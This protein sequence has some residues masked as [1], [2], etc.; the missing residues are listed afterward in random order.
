LLCFAFFLYLYPLFAALRHVHVNT[1]S[2]MLCLFAVLMCGCVM[3]C[4][5]GIPH[6]LVGSHRPTLVALGV[7]VCVPLGQG[8]EGPGLSNL[9]DRQVK[10]LPKQHL[11]PTVG[12]SLLEDVSTRRG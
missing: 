1:R 12:C 8:S 4:V 6:I 5:S 9:D 3:R 2:D 7:D 10:Y 11:E